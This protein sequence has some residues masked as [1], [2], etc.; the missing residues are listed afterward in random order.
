MSQSIQEWTRPEQHVMAARVCLIGQP[1]LLG[2]AAAESLEVHS[3]L[4]AWL[5]EVVPMLAGRGGGPVFLPGGK[6]VALDLE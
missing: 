1:V 3:S 4:V 6:T 2:L 5:G